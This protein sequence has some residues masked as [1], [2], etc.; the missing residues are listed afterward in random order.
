MK[1]RLVAAAPVLAA[2]LILGAPRVHA[3]APQPTPSVSFAP[4]P[5]SPSPGTTQGSAAATPGP[6]VYAPGSGADGLLQL[7]DLR[8]GLAPTFFEQTP[9]SAFRVHVD[10][11]DW[12]DVVNKSLNGLADAFLVLLAL[13]GR[14]AV[15]LMEWAF[16]LSIFETMASAVSGTV[17][18]LNGAIYAPVVPAMVLLA[19]GYGLWHVLKQRGSVVVEGLVWSVAALLAGAVFMAAP[20]AI[21]GGAD[22]L[23]GGLSRDVLSAVSAPAGAQGLANGDGID[24]QPGLGGDAA[25]NELRVAADSY[26]RQ[27]VY[28]PWTVAQ[29]GSLDAGRKWGQRWLLAATVTHNQVAQDTIRDGMDPSTRDYFDGKDGGMRLVYSGLALVAGMFAG[30]LILVLSASAIIAQL[31]LVL[32]VLLGPFF[33]L[34]GVVPGTG[35]RIATRWLEMLV[36]VLVKRV[37]LAALLAVVMVA[38]QMLMTTTG[39]VGWGLATFL[40]IALIAAAFVYRKPFYAIF[41]SSNGAQMLENGSTTLDGAKRMAGYLGMGMA[42]SVAQRSV[43]RVGKIGLGAVTR[44]AKVGTWGGRRLAS[45]NHSTHGGSRSGAWRPRRPQPGARSPLVGPLTPAW[46]T[47]PPLPRITTRPP[48]RRITAPS[49]GTRGPNSGGPSPEPP[50]KDIVDTT[51]RPVTGR[52]GRRA[53]RRGPQRRQPPRPPLDGGG[54]P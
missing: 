15:G 14:A 33:L 48:P 40:E 47:G 25:T 31:A 24:V 37:F 19:G 23:A 4:S 26:F 53:I 49:P 28:V 9:S 35:R 13:I 8:K 39:A 17:G 52:S 16:S 45:V 18:L 2:L 29:F 20:G 38:S 21:V 36:G 1:R 50:S 22:E 43:G 10:N 27:I 44:T 7:P 30:G 12:T 46:E 3:T 11:L 42:A 34:A 51:A 6:G 54:R 41:A 32:L 5:P